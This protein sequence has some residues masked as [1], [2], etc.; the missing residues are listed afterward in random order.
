MN[1]FFKSS[2]CVNDG[3]SM[4]HTSKNSKASKIII[5]FYCMSAVI[6]CSKNPD[7]KKKA[8]SETPPASEVTIVAP[9]TTSIDNSNVSNFSI[10]GTCTGQDSLTVTSGSITQ[11]IACVSGAW[12]VTLD[13]TVL[14]DGNH[15]ISVTSSLN[16][17]KVATLQITK[18]I[19][20]ACVG[21]PTV[22]S[23]NMNARYVI[24]Q[25]NFVANSANRGGA[26]AANTLNNPIG[27][28]V[29]NGKL[30]VADA[31]NNRVLVYNTLPTTNGVAAD[32][33]IGQP[34]FSTVA[35]GASATAMAG[36]QTIAIDG[37]NLAV[38]EWSNRRVS[39]WPLA[40]PSS[41]SYFWGQPDATTTTLNN[42]GVLANS[43]GAVAGL[44]FA[45]GK[46]FVGDVSNARVLAFSGASIS[47]HQSAINVIGQTDFNSSATGSGSTGFGAPYSV[48][49]DG[50]RLAI[51]DNNADRIMIYNSIPS[52]NGGTADVTWGGWGTTSTTLNSPVGVF[53]G[54]N[55][56]FIADRSNDR[57]LVFNSIPTSSAQVPDAV[58]GQSVFTSSDHNQCNCATAAANTLWGV[59]HIY[60]DGCRLYV[61]DK[62]NNRVLVY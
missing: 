20:V 29:S 25:T 3:L 26:A 53:I 7:A 13:L 60:W 23:T 18:S 5:G 38:T 59:H 47:T 55:K 32:A 51:M 6:G 45:G 46:Y 8:N 56:M 54:D 41:A 2:H 50:T 28:V 35:S 22:F 52:S 16:S 43:M 40:N 17:A 33:V 11:T 42:G 30:Y 31:G 9:A 12:Q 19:A 61:T 27:I 10:T 37:T 44:A 36:I 15:T 4:E 58:L 21:G 14:A 34:D 62:Q 39:F 49:S 48:S 1:I 24:G 57:V